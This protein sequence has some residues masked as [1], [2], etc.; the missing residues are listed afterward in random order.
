[1]RINT[2]KAMRKN[3]RASWLKWFAAITLIFTASIG[4]S[5]CSGDDDDEP[6]VDTWNAGILGTWS[7]DINLSLP[8]SSDKAKC[9]LYTTSLN[10]VDKT[11]V[12][13]EYVVTSYLPGVSAYSNIYKQ[14]FRYAM[15]GE[16][17]QIYDDSMTVLISEVEYIIN[18]NSLILSYVSGKRFPTYSF[19]DPVYTYEAPNVVTYLKN[20]N[21]AN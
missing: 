19:I 15:T 3:R 17:I 12:Q 21:T 9:V 7:Y 2:P 16:K 6:E 13:V 8:D 5:A 11:E 10:F 20:N 1:M 4:F 14:T 18:N